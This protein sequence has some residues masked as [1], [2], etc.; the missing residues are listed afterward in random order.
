MLMLR[1]MRWRLMMLRMIRS[2]GRKMMMLR[3]RKEEEDV[4]EE[5]IS[6][7]RGRTLCEPAQSKSIWSLHKSHFMRKLSDQERGPHVV[8]ACTVDMH[9]NIAQEP[10]HTEIY[11]KKCHATKAGHTLCAS[12]RSRHALGNFTKATLYGNLLQNCCATK[13]GHTLCASLHSRNAVGDFTRAT[14]YG[15]L[16][17]KCRRPAGAP[18]SSTALC[19]YRKNLSVWTH[20]FGGKKGGHHHTIINYQVTTSHQLPPGHHGWTLAP[21]SFGLR[22]RVRPMADGLL[23]PAGRGDVAGAA[24]RSVATHGA[25]AI[26]VALIEDPTQ[27]LL[28]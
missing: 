17:V 21:W 8:R 18:W 19:T 25:V 10:L 3:R 22:G 9:F 26:V 5:D 7:E 4:E 23:R 27:A 1:K 14:L 13:A 2:R 24:R 6:Q 28:R 11:R 20:T 15:N 12:L 16:Q